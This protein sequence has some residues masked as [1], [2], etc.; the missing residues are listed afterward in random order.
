MRVQTARSAVELLRLWRQLNVE[1]PSNVEVDRHPWDQPTFLIGHAMDHF[2]RN[3]VA[4]IGRDE[5][6]LSTCADL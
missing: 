1:P 6:L 3:L 5:G 4:P 2:G